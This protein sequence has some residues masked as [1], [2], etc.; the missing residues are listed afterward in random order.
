MKANVRK[1]SFCLGIFA[2]IIGA[3]AAIPSPQVAHAQGAEAAAAVRFVHVYSGGGPIDI[4]IDNEVVSQ[5]IAFGKAT[6]FAS[7]PNGDRHLQVVAAGQNPSSA[8]IDKTITVDAGK[9]YDVLIGGQQDKLDARSNEVNTDQLA[10][11]QA[12]V[13]FIPGEPGS[14]NVD[15]QLGPQSSAGTEEASGGTPIGFP[16][17]NNSGA[18]SSITDYQDIPAATYCIFVSES[19]CNQPRVNAANIELQE[20]IVYDVVIL[21]QVS[22]NNLTF[23]PLMTPTTEPCTKSLGVG[24]ESDACIR[25]VHT[26]P[27]A[28]PVDLYIDDQPV[29]KAVSYGTPTEFAAVANGEHKVRVVA[30]GQSVDSALLDE[31][32]TFDTGMAYQVVV[33]GI[34]ADD[35]NGDNNLK[36]K[37]EQVNLAPVP[38]GQARVRGIHAVSD[39]GT[40]DVNGPGG[41][42]IFSGLD[43]SDTTDYALL[44]A[45]SYDLSIVD[46]D[47][48]TVVEA[49][50]VKVEAGMVYDIFVVGLKGNN[51]AELLIVTTPASTLQGA[52]AT[53]MV[54]A[55]ATPSVTTQATPVTAAQAT[56]VTGNQQ[57][58]TPVG[59]APVTPVLTPAESPTPAETP[60]PTPSS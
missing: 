42:T 28:G 40:V 26:S 15:L 36:L 33:F 39:V 27:D 49:S 19:G 54:A 9:A 32:M 30:A 2:L 14:E 25:F 35:N 5:G 7:L 1:L 24:Q 53:P 38:E 17:G 23:L 4:Y 3:L 46:K 60:T 11:G 6:E 18:G 51:T 56:V 55:P 57:E 37:Q 12:R 21:G 22:S 31:T 48:A 43:F 47:N 10:A 59:T 16:M 13:R 52:Q 50:G 44:P 45:G 20:G 29:A 41:S 58:S 34:A 8:L